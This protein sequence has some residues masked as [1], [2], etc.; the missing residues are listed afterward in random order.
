MAKE[1]TNTDPRVDAYLAGVPEFAKPVLE[2]LRAAVHAAC[3]EVVEDIK[4]S[5]PHFMLDGK[6]LG[7]MSAFK[8]HC[9]FGLWHTADAEK[10]SEGMGQFGR[11]ESLKDLPP[12][13]ELKKRIQQ[14]AELLRSGAKSP[15]MDKKPRPKLEAPDDLLAALKTNA[16]AKR[17]FEAFA[18]SKQ[19][20]YVEWIIEA[21]REETRA[22]RIA[23]AVEWLAEGKSRNWKYEAC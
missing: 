1:K 16:E 12:K 4:W 14:A 22:K 20:D 7:G 21:K 10:S 15:I 23:Q 3:P 8:A 2:H 17:H 6:I 18:P 19:R 9:G 5:R 13:A 11:I